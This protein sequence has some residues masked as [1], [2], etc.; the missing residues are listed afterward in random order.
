MLSLKNICKTFERN[1]SQSMPALQDIT[2]TIAEGEFVIII[3]A[4][5]SGKSTLLNVIA[6]ELQPDEGTISLDGADI[7]HRP[8]FLRATSVGHVFQNPFQGTCAALSIAENLALAARRGLSRGLSK[9]ITRALRDEY[10][11]RLS[12]L[13]LGLENRLDQKVGALSGGQRQ[14]LT[15]LMATFRKPKLLLLDEH[16]AALDPKSAD[17]IMHLTMDIVATHGV[18]T[19]MVTHSMEQLEEKVLKRSMAREGDTKQ[20][21]LRLLLMHR[22]KIILDKAS[23]EMERM[24]PRELKHRIDEERKRDLLD[25]RIAELLRRQYV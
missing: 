9:A 19:L 4:N 12:A 3:G 6:G 14:A 5:G 21:R 20:S 2:C 16:T 18:T 8:E 24:N 13:K 1:T 11:E 17:L 7:T 25:E 23:G 10:R 15:L 22:G